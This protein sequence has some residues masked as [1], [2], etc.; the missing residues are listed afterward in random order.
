MP[1][2]TKIELLY[3]DQQVANTP[4]AISIKSRLNVPSEIVEG[5]HKVF[6]S[7]S[8]ANDPIRK[9]KEVLFLT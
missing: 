8:S 9:G 7:V 5:P 6:E 1:E 3:I 4:V 2:K